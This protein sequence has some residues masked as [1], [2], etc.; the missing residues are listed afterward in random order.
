MVNCFL[1]FIL[2]LA[3][4]NWLLFSRM[5]PQKQRALKNINFDCGQIRSPLA[6]CNYMLASRPVECKRV[7]CK[8]VH[9]RSVMGSKLALGTLVMGSRLVCGKQVI[10]CTRLLVVDW[11]SSVSGLLVGIWWWGVR[12]LVVRWWW[13]VRLLVVGWWWGRVSCKLVVESLRLLVD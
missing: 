13:S 4:N 1:Q 9:G 5:K 11:W 3:N 7:A 8:L 10:G 12:L 2:K 6:A